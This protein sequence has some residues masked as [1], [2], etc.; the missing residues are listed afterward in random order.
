MSDPTEQ[1]KLNG[2]PILTPTDFV[3]EPRVQVDTQGDNRPIY[4]PMRSA[5]LHWQLN[6]YEEA[7]ILLATFNEL[8]ASGT[9]VAYIPA[10]PNFTPYPAATGTAYQF[11]EY[12]GCT[13]GEPTLGLFF[14]GYPTEVQLLIGNIFTG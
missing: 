10:L 3:W 2:R 12:S 8:Q 4:S 9:V 5:R 7:A 14:Q 1:Y 6:F 11:R 13:L